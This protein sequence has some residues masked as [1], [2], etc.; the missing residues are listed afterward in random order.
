MQTELTAEW[1]NDGT[2]TD[3]TLPLHMDIGCGKGGFLLALAAD[4]EENP[5]AV[6]GKRNYLG[7]ELR[8]SVAMFAK[9]R[10]GRH[11]LA[12]KVDFIGCNANVDLDRFLEKYTAFGE[13]ALVSI[14][15]PDPHFKVS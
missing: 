2:F 8:P 9:E 13:V 15:Y 1:P 11:G 4:R 6:E 14:Q 3:P 7:L 12:G 5:N 10:V